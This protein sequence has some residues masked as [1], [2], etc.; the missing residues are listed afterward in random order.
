MQT[1]PLNTALVCNQS[2]TAGIGIT[3]KS[4]STIHRNQSR[5]SQSTEWRERTESR[6]S[7]NAG[8]ILGSELWEGKNCTKNLDLCVVESAQ[9][10]LVLIMVKQWLWIEYSRRCYSRMNGKRCIAVWELVAGSSL[11]ST[12]CWNQF[13][14][15][16]QLRI[17]LRQTLNLV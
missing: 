13:A 6:N 4:K 2:P 11:G 10:P 12:H 15:V 17:I 3:W 16:L 5:V 14:T 1:T 8:E 9:F 7:E